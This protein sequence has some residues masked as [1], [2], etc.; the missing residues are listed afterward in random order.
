MR[1]SRRTLLGAG[2]AAGFAG[3]ITAS[4]APAAAAPDVAAGGDRDLTRPLQDALDRA[5]RD[6]RP[7]TLGPGRYRTGT[8]RLA[9]GA[10]LVG[11]GPATRLVGLGS[12]AVLTAAGAGRIRIADLAV[13]GGG[14]AGDPALVAAERVDEIRLEGLTLTRAALRGIRLARCGGRVAGC[15]IEAAGVTGLFAYDCRALVV[16][17]NDV[18]DCGDGGILVHRSAVGP[19]GARITGNRVARVAARS[20]GTGEN[21]NGI[22]VYRADDVLVSGN[23]VAD[24]ALSAIRANSASNL[25]ILGNRASR[26]G[27]TAI[28]VEFAFTGAVVAD[29]L[30]DRAVNGISVTNFDQGGRLATVSGNLVRAIGGRPA[31]AAPG[32]DG[33]GLAISVEADTA[34]TGNVVEDAVIGLALGTGA[35]TRDIT[36][37]GNIVRGAEI[38]IG[39]AATGTAG[40]IVLSGNLVSG[41]RRVGVAAL[42]GHRPVTQDLVVAG[43]ASYRNVTLTGNRVLP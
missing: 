6:G 37:T 3:P 31:Y 34:V 18:V 25:R 9:D 35:Y 10:Q 36:A 5:A 24:C 1:P 22:N 20:G 30:I 28:Y 23:D 15:R 19:D 13:D 2:V 29:N 11:V 12:G 42:D 38:G 27:E 4:I 26:S 7:V 14:V 16:D 17:D 33:F 43:L 39:V 8:L 21:G 40:T 32:D 41:S